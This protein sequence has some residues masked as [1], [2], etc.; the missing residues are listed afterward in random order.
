M[1]IEDANSTGQQPNLPEDRKSPRPIVNEGDVTSDPEYLQMLVEYQNARWD[2]CSVLLNNLMKKYPGNARLNEFKKDF[3]FQYSLHKSVETNDREVTVRERNAR[4]RR[5][6]FTTILVILGV[7]IGTGVFLIINLYSSSQQQVSNTDQ[8][9]MLG[10]QVQALLNS[11]QPEK[12]SEILTQMKAISPNDPQVVALG[13]KT[14][15]LLA[16]S[17]LYQQA[18]QYIAAGQDA[19]ALALLQQVQAKAPNFKD[20]A[21]LI[22]QTNNRIQIQALTAAANQAYAD[23]R[24]EDA[25][26]GYEQVLALDP[27]IQDATLKEQLLNS[28]L[29]RIIQM[30]ESNQTTIDDI[31]KAELYYR[32]AIAMIPQSGTPQWESLKKISGS[33]LEVKY[34]QTALALVADP[35]QTLSTVSQAVNYMSKA[36]NLN[37]QNTLLK[38]ESDKIT[39]YQVSFQ[40]YMQMDWSSAIKTLLQLDGMEKNY[41]NGRANDLLYE[42]YVG[43]GN[44][45]F[46]AGLYLDARKDYEAAETLAWEMGTRNNVKVFMVE[47]A[48]G[49]TLG[50]LRD[51]KNAASYYKYA[52][53]SVGYASRAAGNPNFV[54]DL[55]SAGSL[56]DSGAFQDS[57]NLYTKAMENK[58]ALFTDIQINGHPGDCLAFVAAQYFSSVQAILDRNSLPRSTQVTSEDAIMVPYM[59]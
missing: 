6:G 9:Q 33:L 3:D 59:P 48:L 13:I 39:L 10:E 27:S 44:Q 22:T 40:N 32:R 53:E 52:V 23:S 46:S 30:L 26:T 28:Y 4:L 36:A 17:Q 29:R 56:F 14:D 41:A 15:E 58:N 35:T 50:Q 47:L 25:I 34:S 57:Y 7:A 2:E 19:E 51:Y 31:N 16:V 18:Q 20:T 24:W 12:A 37:Q 11:G 1:K 8:I 49:K 42:S 38:N 54:A 5:W 43:R 21:L 45:Y 55:A